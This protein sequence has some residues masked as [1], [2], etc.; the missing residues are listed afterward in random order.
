MTTP[1][2][3]NPEQVLAAI[4]ADWDNLGACRSCG[5]HSSWYEVEDSV[6]EQLE[7]QADPVELVCGSVDGLDHRDIIISVKDLG[8]VAAKPNM[9]SEERRQQLEQD[10]DGFVR[11]FNEMVPED[12]RQALAPAPVDQPDELDKALD[13]AVLPRRKA[14]IQQLIARERKA[15]AKEARDSEQNRLFAVLRHLHIKHDAKQIVRVRDEWD[16]TA[17]ALT[18]GET[19]GE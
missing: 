19:N 9:E 7:D 1:A 10:M 18:K 5:W 15:A 16:R 2:P 13:E 14:A 8:K 12:A 4:E 6:R 17:A 11:R 3:T